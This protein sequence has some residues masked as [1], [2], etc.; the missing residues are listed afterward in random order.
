MA[1]G[2]IGKSPMGICELFIAFLCPVRAQSTISNQFLRPI[3]VFL[4]RGCGRDVL[5]CL[6]LW[7]PGCIPTP[8]SS[9]ASALDSFI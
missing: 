7:L 9:C 3:T 4:E 5:M 6:S 2:K 8:T 1:T